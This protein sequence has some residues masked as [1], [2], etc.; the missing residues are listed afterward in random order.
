MEYDSRTDTQLKFFLTVKDD[1]GAASNNPSTV[2]VTVKSAAEPS[3]GG[4]N[5]TSSG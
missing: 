5:V 3:A 4:G 2:S 1:K